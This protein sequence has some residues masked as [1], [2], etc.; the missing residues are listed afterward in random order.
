MNEFNTITK[1]FTLAEILIT[2]S[3][4]GIV[5]AMTIPALINSTQDMEFKNAWKKSYA[6][7]TQAS[8]LMAQDNGNTLK[9]LFTGDTATVNA[10]GNYLKYTQ[11]CSPPSAVCM[12]SM[13]STGY[14][15]LETTLALNN[16]S[17]IMFLD[18]TNWAKATDC[19]DTGR[20]T[21]L[22]KTYCLEFYLDV[23]GNKG[24]NQF[25]KDLLGGV[26]LEDG[27]LLPYGTS[28]FT[29][30]GFMCPDGGFCNSYQYLMNN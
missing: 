2:I 6:E 25:G 21:P 14:T 19:S 29:T 10:Y 7:L 5:A 8:K 26:I 16:G 1:A 17:S 23:N 22:G 9:G 20:G 27:S 15:N 18:G 4:I 3:I 12:K 11:I 24:P 28:G 30:S 13:V